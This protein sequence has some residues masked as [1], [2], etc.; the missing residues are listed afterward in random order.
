ME[1]K[2]TSRRKKTKWRLG[3]SLCLMLWLYGGPGQPNL[4]GTYNS[5]TGFLKSM[6]F[7][8]EINWTHLDWLQLD[9]DMEWT[10][11]PTIVHTYG[12]HS[13]TV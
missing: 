7:G 2:V 1:A 11:G 12:H 9:V 4:I 3:F 5:G 8:P 13:W 6:G 10:S